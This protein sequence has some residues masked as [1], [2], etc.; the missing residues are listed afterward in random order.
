MLM[1]NRLGEIAQKKSSRT[2]YLFGKNK[3]HKVSLVVHYIKSRGI[4]ISV[5]DSFPSPDILRKLVWDVTWTTKWFKALQTIVMHSTI[6]NDS[7]T[8]G[9]Q[10]LSA[11]KKA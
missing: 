10:Y 9:A 4:S 7:F 1:T 8:N 5:D 6:E 2:I 11:N 3:C